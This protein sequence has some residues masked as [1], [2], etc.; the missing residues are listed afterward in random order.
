MKHYYVIYQYHDLFMREFYKKEELD[1]YLRSLTEVY[2]N[3][4]DFKFRVIYGE[5]YEEVN[6]A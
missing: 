4:P 6:Y 3:D 5:D 2:K 1:N